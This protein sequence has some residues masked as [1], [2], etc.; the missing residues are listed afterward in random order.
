MTPIG[1]GVLAV[2][3]VFRN[4][5]VIPTRS[6]RA[7]QMKI[8]EP[9]AFTIAG[10]DVEVPLRVRTRGIWRLKNCDFPPIRLNFA[11]KETKNT[12][13]DGVDKPKLVNY[14]RDTDQ[15]AAYMDGNGGHVSILIVILLPDK[16]I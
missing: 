13:F 4:Q 5:R 11:G 6:G 15:Y 16:R 10:K 12:V 9:D 7:A 3:A 8:G 14:C 2:D 1:D